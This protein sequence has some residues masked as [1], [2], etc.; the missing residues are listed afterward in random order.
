MQTKR[1]G[2]YLIVS[3]ALLNLLLWGIAAANY[4]PDRENFLRQVLGEIVGSTSMVL[5][6]CTLVLAARPRFLEPYFGGLDR[7]YVTHR[8]VS[9]FAFL[10][11]C[12]HPFFVPIQLFPPMPGGIIGIIMFLGLLVEVLLALGQRVPI[13]G[14]YTQF[15]YHRWRKVHRFVGIFF[16]LIFGHVILVDSVLQHLP[17]VFGYFTAFYLLGTGAYLYKEFIVGRVRKHFSYRVTDIIKLNGTTS[18]VTMSPQKN[19]MSFHAGQ[20]LFVSFDSD[21]ILGEPHPFTISSAP[22]ADDL[23]LT[24]KASGDYTRHL[25]TGLKAGAG[26]TLEGAY[27]RMNYKR[28]A[29]E[30]IWI[31]GGIGVTPFASWVRD[32]GATLDREIDF[33]YGVRSRDEALFVDEFEAA[34]QKFPNFRFH[35]NLS[36]RDGSLTIDK[37]LDAVGSTPSGRDVYICGP[38]SMAYAFEEQFLKAGVPDAQI[39]YEEFNF[40]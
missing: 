12:T 21:A 3:A 32:F 20:F 8:D 7:M 33:F 6:A 22:S 4:P 40:R 39:H 28:G 23:R 10:L 29:R 5:F 13:I 1:I 2:P 36:G 11:I 24:I 38:I 17:Y 25:Q 30:Q 37:I 9:T 15:S 14:T 16:V 35:L 19:K 27:G 26:A 34:A 31:A 18:Q